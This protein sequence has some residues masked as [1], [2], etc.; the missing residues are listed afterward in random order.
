[1]IDAMKAPDGSR[2]KKVKDSTISRR[3]PGPTYRGL[4]GILYRTIRLKRT[5]LWTWR[6]ETDRDAELEILEARGFKWFEWSS[7]E[8]DSMHAAVARAQVRVH[9]YD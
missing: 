2:Q 6:L 7:E 9:S 3:G 1:M 5:S 4:H 8:L